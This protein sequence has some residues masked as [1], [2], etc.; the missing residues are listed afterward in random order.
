MLKKK[1]FDDESAWSVLTERVFGLEI[2]LIGSRF[3]K[4]LSFISIGA[5]WRMKSMTLL[6]GRLE[7]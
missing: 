6:V 5:F 1:A 3:L 4:S 7:Y 2:L